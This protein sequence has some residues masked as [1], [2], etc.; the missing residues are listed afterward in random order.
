MTDQEGS[1][2]ECLDV[3]CKNSINLIMIKSKSSGNNL[4]ECDF[5]VDFDGHRY[6]KSVVL[7]L[8]QLRTITSRLI[9]LGS[10]PK[11]FYDRRKFKNY[12]S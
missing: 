1:L 11:A 9:I 6:E 4:N 3:F 12:C 5:Y 10:Y 8:N 2:L 7:A